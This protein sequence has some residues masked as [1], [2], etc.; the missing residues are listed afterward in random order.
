MEEI[1][2]IIKEELQKLFENNDFEDT[3]SYLDSSGNL[4]G[5]KSPDNEAAGKLAFEELKDAGVPVREPRWHN[6]NP[7]V[8][9]MIDAEEEGS[10]KFINPFYGSTIA[11]LEKWKYPKVSNFVTDILQKYKLY[12]EWDDNATLNIM[13]I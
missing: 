9:F 5:L 3:P 12:G 7:Y 11:K 13:N 8:L 4:V 2:K 1:K 6:N 10:E